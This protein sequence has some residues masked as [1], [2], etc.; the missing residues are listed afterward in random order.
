MIIYIFD[1]KYVM[2]ILCSIGTFLWGLGQW[3][4]GTGIRCMWEVYSSAVPE[5][6]KK[7]S[8]NAI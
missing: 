4:M 2:A 6:E 7:T 1:K 5:I 8:S 3:G